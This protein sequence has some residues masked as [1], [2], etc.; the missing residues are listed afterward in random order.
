M[1]KKKGKAIDAFLAFMFFAMLG[2]TTEVCYT[3]LM[4]FAYQTGPDKDYSLK[5]VSYI[6]MLPIYGTASLLFTFGFPLIAK[7]PRLVRYFAIGIAAL[8][9]ELVT[10][11][12]LEQVTG[13]CPWNYVEGWHLWGYIRLDYL[14]LWMFFG[15]IMEE[16]HLLLNRILPHRHHPSN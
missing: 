4:D 6:W 8:T 9:V 14:P 10:G 11:F 1:T 2:V 5:G 12:I 7:W 15:A 3:A 13:K 16:F